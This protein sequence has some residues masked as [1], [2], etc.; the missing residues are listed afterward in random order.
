[1]IRRLLSV[2]I[3]LALAVIGVRLAMPFMARHLMRSDPL[4]HAD[5]IVVLGSSRLERTIEA[6]SLYDE[7]WAPRILLMRTPDLMRD[8]FRPQLHLRFPVLL[9]VQQDVLNQM[10]VP[11][12]AIILS[13][14]IPESTREEANAVADY[15]R[16]NRFQRIIV[17]TSPYHTARA[18]AAVDRAAKHSFEVIVH[19]DRFERPDPDRWWRAFPDRYDVV[20]EYLSRAYAL[21]W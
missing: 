11:P 3:V 8:T 4:K 10:H 7:G 17:V 2:L 14:T 21:I 5:L 9:E 19:P 20:G 15:A 1:M 16:R 13:P 18:G 6:G 12:S